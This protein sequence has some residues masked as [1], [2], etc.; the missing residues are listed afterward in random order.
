MNDPGCPKDACRKLATI[1]SEGG[2]PLV[3]LFNTD[4]HVR[5]LSHIEAD[6]ICLAISIYGGRM[7]EVAR[8]L[9][10]SRSTLYRKLHE[11]GLH[12]IVG[13]SRGTRE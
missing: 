10:I 5:K 2:R 4:G 9:R 12:D 11:L 13:A 8:R 7:G 3:V 6:I 1:K